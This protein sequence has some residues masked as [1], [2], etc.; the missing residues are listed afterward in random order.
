MIVSSPSPQ[1]ILSVILRNPLI[2]RADLNAIA[3]IAMMDEN[4]SSYVLVGKENDVQNLGILTE[5]DLIR[6]SS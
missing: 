4:S 2:V 1:E 6:I 5:R 3:A